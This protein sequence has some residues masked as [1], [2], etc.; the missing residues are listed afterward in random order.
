MRLQTALEGIGREAVRN[1]VHDIEA[2]KSCLTE[3]RVDRN[4]GAIWKGC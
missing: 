1:S 4:R 2:G 3:A